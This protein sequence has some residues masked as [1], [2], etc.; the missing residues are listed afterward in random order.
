M[1]PV[2]YAETIIQL[3][4]FHEITPYNRDN[5]YSIN[6]YFHE[7]KPRSWVGF[8]EIGKVSS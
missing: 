6:M 4:I 1:I 8:I 3:T 5:T 2:L 7:G